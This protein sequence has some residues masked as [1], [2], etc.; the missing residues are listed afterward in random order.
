[1]A[2]TRDMIR[3][4]D[5]S[6]LHVVVSNGDIDVVIISETK[7]RHKLRLVYYLVRTMSSK[8]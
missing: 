2:L 7:S 3:D 6:N 1:M 8:M 5:I 4:S